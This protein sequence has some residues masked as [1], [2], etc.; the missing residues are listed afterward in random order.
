MRLNH[1]YIVTSVREENNHE[2]SALKSLRANVHFWFQE[3]GLSSEKVINQVNAWYNF[4]FT[5]KE[6]DEAKKEV[7]EELKK[8]C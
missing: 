6:Q 7:I 4:A 8:R 1:D 2:L 3:C 5:Q